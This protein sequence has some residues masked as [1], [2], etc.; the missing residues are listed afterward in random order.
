MIWAREPILTACLA[1][2]RSQT[3][4]SWNKKKKKKKGKSNRIRHSLSP[5]ALLAHW[6]QWGLRRPPSPR[7]YAINF[8][9][10]GG[11]QKAKGTQN[12]AIGR[13]FAFTQV[14]RQPNLTPGDRYTLSFIDWYRRWAT[15]FP[16]RFSNLHHC[17]WMLVCLCPPPP[18]RSFFKHPQC[19]SF[20]F[21]LHGSHPR[22]PNHDPLEV[23][24]RL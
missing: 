7:H 8:W 6:R 21:L 2:W 18:T 9:S 24:T 12:S 17:G 20:T 16:K 11:A 19:F 14:D 5:F 23:E 4:L 1:F 22:S 10:W 13:V 3:D 15:L